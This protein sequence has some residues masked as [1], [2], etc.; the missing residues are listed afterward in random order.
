MAL[1]PSNSARPSARR[2]TRSSRTGRSSRASLSFGSG[3]TTSRCSRSRS[4]RAA[5]V[6]RCRAQTPR[7]GA[8]V[9][10]NLNLVSRPADDWR[11]SAR[12]R[13]YSYN[14]ETPRDRR[15]R[16][17]S[18]T[19]R[20]SDVSSTGGPEL[21]AHSRT[22]LRRRRDLERTQ[23]RRAHRRLH[24]QPQRLRLP[25]LR[26]DRRERA[27]AD[28]RCRRL[29][30][31]HVPRELR[32]SASARARAS[33]RSLL[34]EIGEQ[35]AH[36][37]LRPGQPAP[38][39]AY[40]PGRRRAER[41]WTLQRLRLGSAKT[42]TTTA[43]SACR[44]RRSARSRSAPTISMPNGF[45]GGGTYN[46]ERYAGLQRRGRRVRSDIQRS[47]ARLDD[48][49]DGARPLLL[50]LRDAAADRRQYRGAPLVRLQLRR[51][52]LS[53]QPCRA[54]RCRRRRSCRTSSTSCSSCSST[55][56][57]GSRA[58]WPRRSPT[59]TS[60]FGSST[61][62]SIPS[63]VN[64]IVQPSS[65]VLGYVY[66][67]YTAHSAVFGL[68]YHLVDATC[69][70]R[71]EDTCRDVTTTG[72][73]SIAALTFAIVL[74]RPARLRAQDAA[75]SRR[76]QE[77]YAAQKCQ[78][79]HAIAGKGSKSNPLDGVGTKLSADDIKQWITHPTR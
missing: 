53:L 49:L 32:V 16:S 23:P 30:V 48:R 9:S 66:R 29:A 20:R 78:M 71:A 40:R 60:R 19:T 52:Q 61:S 51:R 1:W 6:H 21:Y 36:A 25:H 11:F 64:S 38:Q 54:A 27:A 72:C 15:S 47:E 2:A 14:N 79:C 10:T 65:L 39:S 42:T 68:R 35:P 75:Q 28:G 45:G 37:A 67:P 76:A 56:G 34:V 57:T 58:G 3:T 62:P 74:A 46:Y 55:C 70:R 17:S 26:S 4:T 63:V 22:T 33:T 13:H 59:C 69:R 73:C 7:P 18:T 41:A 31:G 8:H 43:I 77:V 5:A 24:A 50:D 44:S 12:F